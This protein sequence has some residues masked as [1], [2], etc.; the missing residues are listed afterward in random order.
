MN[1]KKTAK[2]LTAAI[3]AVATPVA[4][5]V[6]L[7]TPAVAQA[8]VGQ[9]VTCNPGG[10]WTTDLFDNGFRPAVICAANGNVPHFWQLPNGRVNYLGCFPT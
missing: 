9:A 3:T 6:A 4:M 7:P 8:Y 10:C 5:T 2:A 1:F